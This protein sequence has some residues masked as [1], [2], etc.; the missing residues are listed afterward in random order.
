M[1]SSWASDATEPTVIS[2]DRP[3]LAAGFC[4]TP[5][6][7]AMRGKKTNSA[8]VS[9]APMATIFSDR[10]AANFSEGCPTGICAWTS[11]VSKPTRPI[12]M[13]SAVSSDCECRKLAIS[14]KKPR[15]KMTIA[16]RLARS[17]MVLSVSS[18]LTRVTPASAPRMVR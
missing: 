7:G 10:P 9:G 14:A 2:S 3:V 8:K 13:A 17:S 1:P 4:G 11:A 15:K 5:H 6:S 16:S 18:M 12:A